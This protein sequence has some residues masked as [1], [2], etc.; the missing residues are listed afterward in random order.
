MISKHPAVARAITEIGI[1]SF[2]INALML[3]MP[4]YM[5]QVY[6]RILPSSSRETLLFL[7]IIA[8]AALALL[9]VLEV[10]RGIYA[11][12]MAARLDVA[13]SRNAMMAAMDSPRA[14]LGDIQTLRDLSTVRTFIASRAVFALFDLPFAPLFIAL[15]W[16]VHPVLFL[17]A[18]GGAVLLGGVAIVNRAATARAIR[19]ASENSIA[20]MMTAQ[21]FVRNAETLRAMGMADN[22]IAVWARRH[23]PALAANDQVA[24][25]NAFF[26]GVSRFLRLGLQIAMLGVGAWLVLDGQMTAGMIFAASIISGRGLQPIDQMIGS[27]RQFVEIRAAWRR[28]SA[29]AASR[30]GERVYTDLPEP[31]G[32][33][34]IEN[35]VYFAPNAGPQS[36]PIIKRINLSVPAGSVVG[37]VGPSGAGKSTL[38]RLLVGAIQPRGGVIRID[39]ADIRNWPSDGIGRHIGYLPQDVELLPGTIAENI[40]RFTPDADDADIVEAAKSAQVHDLVQSMPDGYDTVI[41]PQGMALSG[42]QRQRVGLARAFFGKP[43]LL[44]LDEPNAN[45]DAEGDAALER[46]LDTARAAGATVLIITQRTAIA[47]KVDALLVMRAGAIEDFGPRDEVIARQ[48]KKASQAAAGQK[49]AANVNS[50]SD[51]TPAGKSPFAALGPGLR[52][53]PGKGQ[54]GKKQ[55]N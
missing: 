18:A 11:N 29:A 25:I 14:S 54:S 1:F 43:T 23:A 44:V 6:D 17:L 48:Q 27:W 26:T 9:A 51:D 30:A 53:L 5:L 49:A 36:E 41:G 12:R 8:A 31:K 33:L 15:L 52:P 47:R 7:S 21:S 3:V 34:D 24:R 10:V 42:G 13:Q 40:A 4:L 2:S 16:L 28:F 37:I 32:R 45:L 22:A 20:A 39:G 55:A 38:A 50:G 46:A 19:A 35:L